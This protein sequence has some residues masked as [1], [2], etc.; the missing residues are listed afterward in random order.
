MHVVT[1]YFLVRHLPG[2]IQLG[3]IASH[4]GSSRDA[5][6]RC[7]LPNVSVDSLPYSSS[8]SS[9]PFETCRSASVGQQQVFS[10]VDDVF[11]RRQWEYMFSLWKNTQ[12]PAVEAVHLLVEGM[13]AYV[14]LRQH[15]FSSSS[16]DEVKQ[17]EWHPKSYRS[18]SWTP[19]QL[20]KILPILRYGP[21]TYKDLFHYSVQVL[22]YKVVMVCNAD[23]YVSPFSSFSIPSSIARPS[24]PNA[25]QYPSLLEAPPTPQREHDSVP[26]VRNDTTSISSVF[27]DTEIVPPIAFALTRYEK[28][29][30]NS[31]AHSYTNHNTSNTTFIDLATDA[32]LIHDYRGSHD[33]FIFCPS[34]R[35]PILKASFLDQ[36][37]HRQNCYQ[38]ENVVIYELQ[39]AGYLVLNP[40]VGGNGLKL[41]HC[42]AEETGVRQWFPSVDPTRYGRAPPMSME[43]AI[44]VLPLKRKKAT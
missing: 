23:V 44:N 20:R 16:E 19:M 18:L 37:N 36:V 12:H 34:P 6:N 33:A 1:S 28:E 31:H 11:S 13:E 43:E 30:E 7:T 4:T 8:L 39:K 25:N 24:H 10:P 17:Q 41:I 35:S 27:F 21:P 26:S 40:C 14:H 29:V 9:H 32:P 2:A 38:A 5:A 15:V 22:P 42:H 3:S